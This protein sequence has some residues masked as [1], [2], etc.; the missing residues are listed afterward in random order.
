MSPEGLFWV[1]TNSESTVTQ[2]SPAVASLNDAE[3]VKFVRWN[4]EHW[5]ERW[6][7]VCLLFTSR[8]RGLERLGKIL[9]IP[10]LPNEA[11]VDLQLRGFEGINLDNYI[12]EASRIVNRLGGLAYRPT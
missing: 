9:D 6:V 7:M 10:P 12:S 11:G 5:E 2:S 3:K 4:L 8:H 1:N